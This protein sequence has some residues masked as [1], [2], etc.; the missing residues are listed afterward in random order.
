MLGWC[1]V[2]PMSGTKN[3]SVSCNKRAVRQPDTNQV[4]KHFFQSK[5]EV[6]ENVTEMQQKIYNHEFT[7]SQHKL[8][9]EN[10]GMLQDLKFMQVFDNCTRLVD[11]HY[12]IPFPLRDDVRFPDYKLRKGLHICKEK[13]QATINSRMTI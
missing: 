2:G 12:E 11:G 3:S 5:K 4:G 9:R 1:V 8:S 10:G 13:C 6:K 7:E